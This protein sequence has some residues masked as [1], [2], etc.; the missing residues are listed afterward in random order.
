MYA[1]AQHH[2]NE[3]RHAESMAWFRLAAGAASSAVADC[4]TEM[5]YAARELIREAESKPK[6][7][8]RT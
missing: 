8:A 6:A 4:I 3:K 1:I 2:G 5:D 7:E